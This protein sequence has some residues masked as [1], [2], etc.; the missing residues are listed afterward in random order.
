MSLYENAVRQ[1]NKAADIMNLEKDLKDVLTKPK[2]ELTVNFPVRMDDGTV[3]VFTGYRVQHNVARGPAKGGIRFHSEV[4]LDEVKALAFWMTWKAAVVDIPYGG[5]KGGI[6]VNPK[7]LSDGEL[8]RMSRRFFSEIQIIIGEEKDI[9]A[10]DVNTNGQIMAWFMDT[11]SMNVG[12]T[13]LGIVTGK[14]LE[15]GGSEGRTEAT[16]RGVRICIEEGINYMRKLGKITKENK[17]LTV[18][19]HGFGNVGTYASILTAEEV[20]MKVVAVSDSSGGLYNAEG[21]S[22]AELKELSEKTLSRK[23]SLH[24][25]NDGKYKTITNDEIISLDVDIFSPCAIENTITMDNVDSVK[26]K[27]I[28][29]GANGPLT[30]EADEKLTEKGVFIVPDFLANAGGVTVSYF[31]WV[32]GLQWNFWELE[33]VREALHRKMTKAFY[34]VIETMEEYKTDMRT[35]AYINAVRRVATATK[36]RGIYP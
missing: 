20:G 35:A 30:P 1:F 4:T 19:V 2:R 24:D 11:Y 14:P 10:P 34:D 12:R 6:T 9:P 27:L 29:E 26:A 17:D 5:G 15:I 7:E 36:L 13:E 23:S 25:V 32:Q 21:F 33:D 28:V 16:G 31:E 22:P 18:A 8:E 3:R